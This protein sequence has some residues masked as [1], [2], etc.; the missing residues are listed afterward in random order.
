MNPI[1]SLL[2]LK[3]QVPLPVE[4]VIGVPASKYDATS[5]NRAIGVLDN[6]WNAHIIDCIRIKPTVKNDERAMFLSRATARRSVESP[7]EMRR[8]R[9]KMLLILFPHFRRHLV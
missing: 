9:W 8:N 5:I 4:H 7:S 1:R 2:N 6:R 3:R